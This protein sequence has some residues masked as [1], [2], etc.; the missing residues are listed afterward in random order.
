MHLIPQLELSSS[1]TSTITAD[2]IIIGV[3][4]G[5]D[6]AV[7]SHSSAHFDTTALDF[8]ALGVS[9][10]ADT[11]TR[12]P[13]PSATGPQ[14]LILIGIGKSATP[15]ALRN[16]VGSAIRKI[17]GVKTVV[18]ALPHSD[19]S[20]LAAILEGATLGGYTFNE[21]RGVSRK[22]AQEP[23]SR[24]IVHSKFSSND[25]VTRATVTAEAVAM[26]KDLVNTP[27]NDLFP[28]SMVEKSLE[29]VDELPI[30]HTVWTEKELLRDGFGGIMG[31]GQGSSRLPRLLRL[32]YN[33]TNASSHIALVG[34]G[35]TFDTGGLSLK[36]PAAMVGMKGDMAGAAS[37]LAIIWAAAKLQLPIH[38]TSWLPLAENM[39]SSTATRPGDVIT[40]RNGT[41]VEVLNTDAEG[42]LVL[43][44]ALARA[45]EEN[46]DAII[47]IATLTGAQIVALGTRTSGL[48]GDT[49]LV[50]QLHAASIRAGEPMWPMPI[51]DEVREMLTSDIADIANTKIGN[52][53]A[54]MMLAA[55]FLRDFTTVREDDSQ[56]TIPWAHIDIAGPSNN[57]GSAFGYTDRGATGVSVRTL[58]DFL[59]N[60]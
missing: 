43:A 45:G 52:V 38:I 10:A 41:T 33:P 31:V 42:R 49:P 13:T 25:L 14:T 22:K 15:D 53:A 59:R 39:P 20:E 3:L 17:R 58:I 32:D 4:Q 16:A 6:R 2:A 60:Y 12:I 21:F 34:K 30:E 47:D 23:V 48:M 24:V 51:P 40:I 29:Y 56:E 50:D 36:P 46:P 1:S 26:V 54:S 9:G 37:V 28:A 11:L 8:S 27:A 5:K 35:I 19:E 18:V 55:A 44:D 7:V 57:E